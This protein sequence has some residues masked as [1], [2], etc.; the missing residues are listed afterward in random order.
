MK[1]SRFTRI[2]LWLLGVVL[3]L[4]LGAFAALHYAAQTLRD[5][6]VATLGSDSEIGAV[7][8]GWSAITLS[9]L[10]IKAP[11]GWPAADALRASRIV[12]EPDLRALLSANVHVR[13][14][15]IEGAYLSIWRTAN[16]KV[17]LLPSLLERARTATGAASAPQS[18]SVTIEHIVLQDG[19]VD[20]Y[21]STIRKPAH[22]LQLQNTDIAL[23][24]LR[25]PALDKQSHLKASA[26]LKGVQRDGKVDIAGWMSFANQDSAL[27]TTLRGVD[28]VALQPYLIKASETGV[29]T[30]SL[31]L[32]LKSTI[33]KR[34]LHAPGTITLRNLELSNR[35]GLWGTFMGLPR[36]MVVN[37]MKD[38]QGKIALK[39]TLDGNL[40]DPRF[41]LNENMTRRISVGLAEGLGI[42]IK[43]MAGGIGRTIGKLFGQ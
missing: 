30:G 17:R 28:L 34:H 41:S 3:I 15:S 9:Q 18:V 43:G 20:F 6:V 11:A 29:K 36:G 1:S 13:K 14:I 16:G 38:Q 40:D 5:Q 31:D 23:D 2:L 42:S 39:F 4:T 27:T 25:L 10:R 33:T 35:D 37:G 12:V 19:A 26:T 22:R 8:L 7:D 21:D 32:D 24:D